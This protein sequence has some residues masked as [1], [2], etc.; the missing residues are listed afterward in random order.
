MTGEDARDYELEFELELRLRLSGSCV[1]NFVLAVRW[2][3]KFFNAFQSYLMR[4]I[5]CVPWHTRWRM[6]TAAI[7]W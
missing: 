1:T 3:H 5:G 4:Y 7:Q 6:Y 2:L